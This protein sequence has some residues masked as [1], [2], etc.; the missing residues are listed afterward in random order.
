MEYA[1]FDQTIDRGE[2]SGSYSTK[3]S[4]F[5]SR[6]PGYDVGEDLPMWVADMDFLCPPAVIEAV[7]NRAKHGIYGYTNAKAVDEFIEAASGWAQ[8]RY[9]W[10]FEPSWGS[11]IPGVVP[12]INA[13]IQE[14]TEEGDG[15]IIQRPVYYPFY[16]GVV[17]TGRVV[18]NNGLLEENG[19]YRMDFEGLEALAEDP[20]T[21]LMVLCSP[22][23]P[24][25]RVW[26]REELDRVADICCRNHV[27]LFSDEIHADLIFSGHTHISAGTLEGEIKENVI[28]AIA[29]SKTFNLAGLSSAVVVIQNDK[30]RARMR[31]R[32]LAN[33]LPKSNAFGPLAGAV[34]YNTGDEYVDLLTQYVEDNI[35]YAMDYVSRYMP[36]VKI[37]KNEGTYLVWVD[38]R[39]LKLSPEDTNHF[40]LEKAKVAGD[41]GTWFGEAGGGFVRLNFACPRSTLAAALERIRTAV[42]ALRKTREV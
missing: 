25:G 2:K 26:T 39:G 22:H 10:R 29:P 16:D 21:K 12:A 40:I 33:R 24:V 32:I 36:E 34:A 5:E 23:N 31:S 4:G 3:W 17:N 15:V 20:R 42:E 1:Y 28:V 8:R 19:R 41:I 27:I 14:F 38:L 7:Q 13:A 30:L 11:F 18:R 9:G 35:N 37:N 6:F